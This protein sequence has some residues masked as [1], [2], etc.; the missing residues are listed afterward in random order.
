MSKERYDTHTGQ[1]IPPYVEMEKWQCPDHANECYAVYCDANG[2][3]L[4]WSRAEPPSSPSPPLSS[5]PSPKRTGCAV[6]FGFLAALTA[7]CIALIAVL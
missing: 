5:S 3:T 7:A 1:K 4:D 2:T 6:I